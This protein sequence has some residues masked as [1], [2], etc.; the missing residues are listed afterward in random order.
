MADCIFCDIASGEVP[1]TI[2]ERDDGVLAFE[3]V[4]PK[5]PLHVLV[6]PEQH[7]ESVHDIQD[8]ALLHRMHTLARRVAVARGVAE[9]GY[10]LVFNIGRDAGQSVPHAHLHLLGGR[11]LAWPPG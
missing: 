9:G 3:D 2:V 6:I 1:A 4:N 10:R 8:A 11:H 5:A 7:L